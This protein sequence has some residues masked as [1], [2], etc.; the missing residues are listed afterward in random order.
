VLKYKEDSE[1]SL[2]NN[3]PF[4]KK[5]LSVIVTLLLLSSVMLPQSDAA[6]IFRN[7]PNQ[8]LAMC[9]STQEKL[10]ILKSDATWAGL[11][12][13][14]NSLEICKANY[15]ILF[16]QTHPKDQIKRLEFIQ[17]TI[18][19]KQDLEILASVS[20]I[21]LVIFVGY[22]IWK[23]HRNKQV[24]DAHGAREAQL[25]QDI[26]Q[27]RML[28]REKEQESNVR[29]QNMEAYKAR[30]HE[31]FKRMEMKNNEMI[32]QLKELRSALEINSTRNENEIQA[33]K[34]DLKKAARENQ[35]LKDRNEKEMKALKDQ[36]EEALKIMDYQHKKEIQ[37]LQ[38]TKDEEIRVIQRQN[39]NMKIESKR[40]ENKIKHLKSDIEKAI[41]EKQSL[42]D[43]HKKEIQ[44]L[45][46]QK[47][48]EIQRQT[49]AMT[50]EL[51]ELKSNLEIESIRKQN[52]IKQLKLYLEKSNLEIQSLK[53]Q[54]QNEIQALKEKKAKALEI[55]QSRKIKIVEKLKELKSNLRKQK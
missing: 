28:L 50:E 54:H 53:D 46:A 24:E 3:S 12:A 17:R 19:Q 23:N 25:N 4:F 9:K 45:Q 39:I 29:E 16:F 41:S 49:I 6:H 26:Q 42:I 8:I 13:E 27:V 34:S 51:K 10:E 7:P 35:A 22:W 52:E 33:L 5:M 36:K 48:D 14:F 1:S 40:K 43:Q 31:E 18:E 15:K 20:A 38:A 47:E 21:C 37:M 55:T 2:S 44:I 11:V 32:E 30:K